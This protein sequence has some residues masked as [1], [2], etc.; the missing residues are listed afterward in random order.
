MFTPLFH[1][2]Y[3]PSVI[4]LPCLQVTN[5]KKGYS[6]GEESDVEEERD[7][8]SKDRL[9][10]LSREDMAKHGTSEFASDNEE[11]RINHTVLDELEGEGVVSRGARRGD[12]GVGAGGDGGDRELVNDVLSMYKS[13]EDLDGGSSRSPEAPVV[14]PCASHNKLVFLHQD[15]SP[16]TNTHIAKSAPNLKMPVSVSF[17]GYSHHTSDSST[18]HLH[19]GT[20]LVACNGDA[21]HNEDVS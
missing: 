10:L 4:L 11:G 18:A 2:K 8:V 7:D 14:R 1:A 15:T 16:P 6:S 13:L 3:V 12:P 21:S 20:S 5:E 9:S 17:T 19:A